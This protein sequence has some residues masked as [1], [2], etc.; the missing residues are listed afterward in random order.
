MYFLIYINI[1]NDSFYGDLL[2][3]WVDH[4]EQQMTVKQ[5]VR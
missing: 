4:H 3:G 1:R 2:I 5:T